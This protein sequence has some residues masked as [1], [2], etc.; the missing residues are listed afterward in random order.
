VKVDRKNPLHWLYLASS[1]LWVVLA[2][3]LRPLL[4]P[5]I[6]DSARRRVLLYGHKLGGNLLALQRYLV[7]KHPD[8][9]VRFITLD[10][11]YHRELTHRGERSLLAVSPQSLNW[12]ATAESLVS[13]HGLHALRPL[14]SWS[15]MQFFDVWHGIPFK[16]FDAEDFRVQ[17]RYDGVWV[18]SEAIRDL[19]ITRFG[20]SPE[21][22]QVTGYARTDCLVDRTIDTDAIKRDLGLDPETCG[23]LVLFAPTW[24]QDSSDRMVFPFGLEAEVFLK[25]LSASAHAAG[26]TVLLR[27]HLNSSQLSVTGLEHIVPVPY[28]RFPDTEAVLLAS[29]VLICDW[30]SIAFDFLLLDRPALFLDVEAPFRKGF[31]LGPEYRYGAVVRSLQELIAQL[32][33]SLTDADA[34]WRAHRDRHE[35]IKQRVY[36]DWA[37]GR[38]SQRCATKLLETSA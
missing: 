5:L 37:D 23:R 16:G 35:L 8:V 11:A 31:S 27:L 36:G 4:R 17:H 19:Y 6:R 13:D 1:G 26:A 22:V 21:V 32:E 7:E 29:D 33:L 3:V 12:L 2:I 38:S 9:E 14:L 15:D 25:A 18:A 24:K 10:P 20:F 34:Y 30:S 28:A